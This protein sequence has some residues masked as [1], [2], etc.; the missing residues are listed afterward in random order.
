MCRRLVVRFG[1]AFGF[2]IVVPP[3]PT[4][5]AV[6]RESDEEHNRERREVH[7]WTGVR[8]DDTSG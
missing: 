8:G 5:D 4:D 2:G 7:G 3:T 1:L 6:G